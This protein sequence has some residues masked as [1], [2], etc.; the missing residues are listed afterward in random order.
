MISF[1]LTDFK[2]AQQNIPGKAFFTGTHAKCIDLTTTCQ[3]WLD[4]SGPIAYYD[5]SF[6]VPDFKIPETT[7]PV[8]CTINLSWMSNSNRSLQVPNY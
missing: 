6:K 8:P 7:I 4:L 3:Y 5:P 1:F 2:E